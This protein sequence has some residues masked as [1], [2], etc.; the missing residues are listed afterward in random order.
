MSEIIQRMLEAGVHYGFSKTRNHPS[1]RGVIF[2]FKN[3]QAIIDLEKTNLMLEAA[4]RFLH[5]LGAE[6]KVIMLVG[7][8]EEAQAVIKEAAVAENLPYVALR[9]LGGILTNFGQ[10]K[11]RV[12]RLKN[13][14]AKTTDGTLAASSKKERARL[15]KE[16]GRLERYFASLSN[17]EKLPDALLVVDSDH[18]AIAVA[19]AQKSGIPVVSI[20]GTDCN[21]R[22]I[23]YPIVANDV[24]VESIRFFI[25]EL[26]NAYKEGKTA[27]KKVDYG[28]S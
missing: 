20:S 6:G 17:L 1:T 23:D 13:L 11:T 21:I 4:K 5:G 24:N 14:K 28:E 19:E 10:L 18:E 27:V 3:R 9:W 22:G 15:E 12:E 25:T 2:G 16:I 8:K 7:N 26:M